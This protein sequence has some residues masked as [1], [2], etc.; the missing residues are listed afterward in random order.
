M[1]SRVAIVVEGETNALVHFDV[2]QAFAWEFLRKK[3][4]I[5]QEDYDMAMKLQREED[6]RAA[7][8]QRKHHD[9][10]AAIADSDDAVAAAMQREE[11]ERRQR[12]KR[13]DVSRDE[14]LARRLASEENADNAGGVEAGAPAPPPHG[15][16][17]DHGFD[18]DQ[19]LS[20]S[21]VA[22]ALSAGLFG[23]EPAPRHPPS[24]PPAARPAPLDAPFHLPPIS[25]ALTQSVQTREWKAAVENRYLEAQYQKSALQSDNDEDIARK[26]EVCGW[27]WAGRLLTY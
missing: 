5:T 9:A 24:P 11:E 8:A 17:E 10:L 22:R 1:S 2:G 4:H 27:W 21:A 14:E 26:L 13:E 12:Q 23:E 20:D 25:S 6:E 3:Q 15:H 7:D 19:G 18:G 16:A